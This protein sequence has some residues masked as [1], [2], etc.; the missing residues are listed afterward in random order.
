MAKSEA[1]NQTQNIKNVSVGFNYSDV[2][3]V[4]VVAPTTNGTNLT[5]GTRTFTAAG[6]TTVSGGAGAATWTCT[7]SGGAGAARLNGVPV[8]TQKGEYTATPT[9]SGN[10]ATVDSGSSDATWAVTVG[11]IKELYTAGAND[12]LL[13][14]ISV[15]S[16]DTA[17]RVVSI[18]RQNG[19]G[20]P[21][22]LVVA[23][24][25]AIAAGSNGSTAAQ[26][27]LAT[28]L[29]PGAVVDATGKRVLPLQ[30]GAKLFASVPGVT[31]SCM[32]RVN[33]TAEEF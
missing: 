8:I 1:L 15:T 11:S 28:A 32:I 24:T 5:P 6:G 17:A 18:W 25:V 23:G 4:I 22:D 20:Q 9:A 30:A 13:K 10:A 16:T 3:N 31:A 29:I 2:L 7:A 14:S 21:L 33:A 19:T 27:L 26:D 12:A